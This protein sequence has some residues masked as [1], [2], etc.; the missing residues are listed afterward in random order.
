MPRGINKAII[1][2][3]LGSDPELKHT[4]NGT[5]VVNLSVATNETWTDKNTGQK[6]ERTEWH[7]IVAWGKLGEIVHQ[8]LKKGDQA[9]FEG[10]I[11]TEKWQDRDGND[12]YT[13]KI[14]A[15]DMQ[16]LDSA[17]GNSGS[18]SAP[19]GSAKTQ[20][21]GYAQASAGTSKPGQ[22][23]NEQFDDIPF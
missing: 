20:P 8:Y 12:R 14:I 13:T 19:N 11:Q 6:N 1:V 9:Y 7:R 2:G 15:R 5:A 10:I 18:T 3:T 4:A 17:G 21:N 22:Q 16:M 23:Q